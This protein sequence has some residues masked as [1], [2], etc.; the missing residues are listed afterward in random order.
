MV[1][2]LAG[3]WSICLMYATTYI[4]FIRY[5]KDFSDIAIGI[6]ISS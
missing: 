3:K 4:M 5:Q 6:A 2:T 1:S